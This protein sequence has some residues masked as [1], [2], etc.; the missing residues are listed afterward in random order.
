MR[1]VL[2]ESHPS[3]P[4]ASSGALPSQ[5]QAIINARLARL[6]VRARQL[7]EV[8]AI[9]GRAFTFNLLR[10]ASGEDEETLACELDELW[11]RRIV[12]EQGADAYD[13][14]HDKLRQAVCASLSAARNRLL[15]R[16]V[17][18]A[19]EVVHARDLDSVCGQVATHYEQAGVLD[20]AIGYYRRAAQTARSVYANQDAITLFR[21]ALD[22]LKETSPD[23]ASCE[24]AIRLYEELGDVCNLAGRYEDA[25]NAYRNAQAEALTGDRVWQAQ[26]WRKTGSTSG[27]S[28]EEQLL[29]FDKAEQ[30]LGYEPVEHATGWWQEWLAIYLARLGAHYMQGNIREMATLIDVIRPIVQRQ[31]TRAQQAVF[32][33]RLT[34]VN[35]RRDRF[36]ITDETLAYAQARLQAGHEAADPAAII[37]FTFGLGFVYLWRGDLD[38]AEENLQAALKLADQ[39][40]WAQLRMQCL[41]YLTVIY[42]KRRQVEK[43]RHWVS[44]SLAA[45]QEI[46][47]TTYIA[48]AKANLAWIA[49]H[50][51]DMAAARLLGQTALELWAQGDTAYP[52]HWAALWPLIAIALAGGEIPTAIDHARVLLAPSQQRLP[53]ALTSL[54]EKTL[55]AWEQNQPE[56]A[57]DHLRRAVELAQA[58]GY[59]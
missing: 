48:M 3:V 37:D 56:A 30:L 36:V 34:Q 47:Q 46:N 49:W 32:Y 28:V 8:A 2:S 18:E 40:G 27:Q 41:T 21:R 38:K 5:V 13:F 11:Q 17:A 55:R 12:R 24:R 9:I 4:P 6:S 25:R 50:D 31:G 57:H 44:R 7:M 16:R 26:L 14:T 53:D 52:L 58:T 43:A 22:L 15:H 19:M 54:L 29:S 42:R 10:Q 51:G 1:A 39:S 20:R 45:A 59:F 35:M 23:H 33:S